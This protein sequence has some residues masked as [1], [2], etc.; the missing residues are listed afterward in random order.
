MEKD[1]NVLIVDDDMV[2][3]FITERILV[4]QGIKKENISIVKNGIE[5][6]NYVNN[7]DNFKCPTL[8]LLDNFMPVASGLD[9]LIMLDDVDHNKKKEMIIVMVSS[10]TKRFLEIEEDIYK[11]NNID[12]TLEKP[13]NH[14]KINR[15]KEHY[16]NRKLN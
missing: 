10:S 14:E 13:I 12:L 5:A 7:C 15:V 1:M 11:K 8:I 9:F 2:S 16:K 3:N 6:F 4:Q